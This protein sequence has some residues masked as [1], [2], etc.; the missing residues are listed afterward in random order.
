MAW[1]MS[2]RQ[3]NVTTPADSMVGATD[4]PPMQLR[5]G[6]VRDFYVNST[7]TVVPEAEH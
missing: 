2:T 7:Y 5:A 4:N 1:E 3:R 6:S